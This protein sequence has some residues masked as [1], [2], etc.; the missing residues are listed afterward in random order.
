MILK[1]QWAQRRPW[2]VSTTEQPEQ[3]FIHTD[4]TNIFFSGSSLKE[5]ERRANSWLEKLEGWLRVNKLRLNVKKTNFIVFHA[6]NKAINHNPKLYFGNS[7]IACNSSC[8]FLGVHFRN[9]LS[10]SDHVIH[11]KM[12][13][14]R[15]IGVLSRINHL[16]PHSVAK[17]LY[18]SL[19]H[20]HL[21]YCNLV[22]GTCNKTDAQKVITMQQKA[23]KLLTRRP[24]SHNNLFSVFHVLCFTEC[25]KL[26]LMVL[27]YNRIKQ[28]FSSFSNMYLTRDIE[29]NLRRTSFVSTRSRTNYGTQSLDHQIVDIC[30]SFP[31][32]VELSQISRS[33]YYFKKKVR[34]LFDPG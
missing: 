33:V 1:S 15:S 14:A 13:M 5:L 29:Y 6:K 34:L 31:S 30:N 10:W 19:V 4:D 7:E 24:D 11:V 26:K 28:D 17:Q 3:P 21:T 23:L 16:V 25:Y 32:V 20:S 12:K 9:D 27:I 18:F 2:I 8:K 22:W